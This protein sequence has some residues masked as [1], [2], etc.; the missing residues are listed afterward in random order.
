LPKSILAASLPVASE[1]PQS[2]LTRLF[3]QKVVSLPTV[4]LT[5]HWEWRAFGSVSDRFL[6]R[7]DGLPLLYNGDSAQRIVDDY[8]WIPGSDVNLKF[9]EGTGTQ[10]GLKFKRFRRRVG[11]LEQW[12]ESP[13]EIFG[14]PLSESAWETLLEEIEEIDHPGAFLKASPYR[15]RASRRHP[16]FKRR[17][18]LEEVL[19]LLKKMDER[20]R[21]VRVIKRRRAR[22]WGEN[23]EVK[24]ELAR[25]ESP[26]VTTSVGLEIWSSDSAVSDALS[27]KLLLRAIEDLDLTAESLEVMNYLDF[28]RRSAD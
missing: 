28:M 8:L 21:T 20:I 3:R 24:V 14:F 7:F 16:S 10:D 25:I 1:I 4:A 12:S 19:A 2:S 22:L 5:T 15:A 23:R 17:G 6:Q 26:K 13:D 11:D 18:D 27:R 9:R